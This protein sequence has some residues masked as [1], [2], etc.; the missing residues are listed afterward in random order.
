[1]PNPVIVYRNSLM[2]PEELEAAQSA[3]FLCSP[4]RRVVQSGDT[5]IARY[6]A[7]PFYCEQE[8]DFR[9]AGGA[10]INTF[11]EHAFVADLRNYV[12]VLG[13]LTPKTWFRL[14]DAPQDGGPFI[15]KG[16]TNSKKHLWNTHCYAED[17]RAACAVYSNLC[18]DSKIGDQD[19]YVRQYVPLCRLGT[20]L[21]G[22]PLTKE[23]RFFV[24]RG[25]VLSGG[26]YWDSYAE[27]IEYQGG[28]VPSLSEVP[29]AF[30][31]KVIGLVAA[32][33]PFF[34]VDVAQT[35]A[36]DWIVVELNDGQMS[37]LSA[38]DPTEMYSNLLKVLSK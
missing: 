32:H 3:G 30:I 37:G 33:V 22:L 23:F 38:N 29:R 4:T 19:I 27:D 16:A 1:M 31:D 5:V 9:L 25:V 14:E 2:P 36:G 11:R 13:D 26:F 35:A 17:W 21:N 28:A 20:A 12:G 34:A 7:L 18:Q 15:L 8:E 6:S 24:C 10:M